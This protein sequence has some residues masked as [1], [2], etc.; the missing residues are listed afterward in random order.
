MVA[1]E[2]AYGDPPFLARLGL[3]D[4]DLDATASDLLHI[5]TSI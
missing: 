3:D 1:M 2:L 5:L 4:E